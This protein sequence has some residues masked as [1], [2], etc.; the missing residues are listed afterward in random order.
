M[1]NIARH[2]SLI[3]D[4]VVVLPFMETPKLACQTCL[5]RIRQ[6]AG[7]MFLETRLS[8]GKTS[9]GEKPLTETHRVHFHAAPEIVLALLDI[10]D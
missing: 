9:K 7:Y 10:P 2:D 4:T 6:A 5:Q 3:V 8:S 1:L